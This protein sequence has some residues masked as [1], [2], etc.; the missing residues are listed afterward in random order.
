MSIAS[1]RQRQSTQLKLLTLE[2][3]LTPTAGWT[4]TPP[5]TECLDLGIAGNY[6]AFVFDD[7][8]GKWSE[9]EGRLAVG[10]TASLQSYG[11]GVRLNN[12]Y[13]QRDDLIVGGNLNF[14]YGQS[15][16]GNIV[17]GGNANLT[18]IGSPNGTIRKGNVID[19][20]A[21]E[22][23]LTNRSNAFAALPSNGRV[24]KQWGSI[25][26]TGTSATRNVFNLSAADFQN[27]YGLSIKVPKGS[28]VIINVAGTDA[29]LQYFGIQLNG[30]PASK[31]LF[32]FNQA[33]NIRINGIG[34]EGS[35]LAPKAKVSFD[36]GNINGTL[37]AESFCGYGE[38]RNVP[39]NLCVDAP[40]L[41]EIPAGVSSTQLFAVGTEHGNAPRVQAFNA[42][43]SLRFSFFAY[44]PNVTTGVRVATGDVNG[45]GY[46]DIITAA[47]AGGGPN[48]KVFDG[49][50]GNELS[51]F[52]AYAPDFAK[53]VFVA[54]GDVN[55]DGYA[56]IITG[57]GAGGGPHVKVF[58]GLTGNELQSFFAYMPNYAG[59]VVV[60][61]GDI[62]GDGLADIITGT[63]P[64]A[65]AHVRAF[66]GQSLAELRSFFAYSPTFTGG[67]TL[68]VGDINGDGVD[69]I[70]AAAGPGGG[71]HIQAFDGRNDQV[72]ASFFAGPQGLPNGIKVSTKDV[73]GDGT[74]DFITGL[75]A[76][77]IPR[78]TIYSGLD[79]SVLQQ[80]DPYEIAYTGGFSIG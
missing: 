16:S 20:A 74:A 59:G 45:D 37:V 5:P 49:L 48:V 21:A 68:S 57:A 4:P 9:T 69:D 22:A 63:G 51:S 61:T 58:D 65:A 41:T 44:A 77:A 76:G 23:D 43:G 52:F 53:G 36:N 3:R 64:G 62:D 17:Y 33:E 26:L 6:N 13:G 54:A 40:C 30:S 27:C 10:G 78:L 46:E 55:G 25:T 19:F 72:I 73:N 12:S 38:L 47:G 32:N 39:P 67:L 24:V 75:G 79:Q 28:V 8:D 31:V 15:F 56:D 50:T 18:A 7:Y 14:T 11:I 60:A 34:I 80:F 29:T 1:N 66:K 2:D 70:V 35:V 42:D 71:P